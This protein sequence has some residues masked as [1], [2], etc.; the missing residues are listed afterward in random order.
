MN[1][2]NAR[3]RNNPVSNQNSTEEYNDKRRWPAVITGVGSSII[4]GLIVGAAW[5]EFLPAQAG[6]L[7]LGVF[8]WGQSQFKSLT[9]AS[10]HALLTGFSGQLAACAG[11]L[12]STASVLAGTGALISWILAAAICLFHSMVFV[13]FAVGFWGARILL[14]KQS[15]GSAGHHGR[16]QLRRRRERTVTDSNS[17][18]RRY[19]L[20]L[21]VQ[22]N[23]KL[24]PWLLLVAPVI[25]GVA[26]FL[27]PT[28]YP[29][30]MGCLLV[31]QP[32]LCQL[33]EVGGTHLLS[34]FAVAISVLLPLTVVFVR[35]LI[36]EHGVTRD[37]ADLTIPLT[38]FAVVIIV[39]SWS[40]QRKHKIERMQR[41]AEKRNDGIRI[42]MVQ[43]ETETSLANGRMIRAS[44]K[45]SAQADLVLWP[46]AALGNY[47][48]E[49]V[50]FSNT[51]TVAA[52][53][54]GNNTRFRPF[55]NPGVF[56][57]AGAD[58][59]AGVSQGGPSKNFV[60]ALLLDDKE[61]LVGRH[62]KVSLM[63]Y[64]EY[65]PGEKL[66]PQIR[67]WLGSTRII[68]RGDAVATIG[69][70]KG[71]RLGVLLC[72]E[73]MNPELFRQLALQ[74][75]DILISLGNGMAFDDSLPLKQHLRIS[76]L[77]AI[78]N[79]RYFARCMSRGVSVLLSPAGE[80]VH[81][82]PTMQDGAM[83]FDVP[84]IE[85]DITPYT[86]YGNA[87]FLWFSSLYTI[88]WLVLVK[89]LN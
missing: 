54:I 37:F 73:D 16:R 9:W 18:S 85:N 29:F 45:V 88:V 28:F 27:T 2:T 32:A 74:R 61:Q 55:P 82:L 65:I 13:V 69:E 10:T 36:T 52:N 77:R 7:G 51:K 76:R 24:C 43:A 75:A 33:A 64:G 44:R 6:L 81:Q 22:R 58:T 59:W 50:D 11:W 38:M 4:A 1:V 70:L 40:Y 3:S 23:F 17:V 25:W 31:D 71:Q 63:P 66:F 53:S 8:V 19:L 48:R 84:A 12:A 87:P 46:E 21:F 26:E 41:I 62:D 60:S 78:E 89:R 49:L 56:L 67:K 14:K 57:L 83:L 86:K 20:S 47:N 30:S 35:F 79:R 34:V 15:S 5:R 68:S 80:I 72:C 39:G 42:L